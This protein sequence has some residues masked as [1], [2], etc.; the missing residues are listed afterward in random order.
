[1]KWNLVGKIRSPRDTPWANAKSRLQAKNDTCVFG[2][3]VPARAAAIDMSNRF[4]RKHDLN[5]LDGLTDER[6]IA[7]AV[8]ALDRMIVPYLLWSKERGLAEAGDKLRENLWS[9]AATGEPASDEQSVEQLYPGPGDVV[10]LESAYAESFLE[11]LQL[12][13]L[14]AETGDQMRLV[15][16]REAAYSMADAA[17]SDMLVRGGAGVQWTPEVESAVSFHPW[18]LRE[19]QVQDADVMAASGADMLDTLVDE[20]RATSKAKP[21]VSEE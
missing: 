8:A 1:M 16:I 9:Y 20:L 2:D 14:F 7:V 18:V 13:A 19:L 17:A 21:V 5:V 15:E 10:T 6:R 4:D 11:A 3:G 12:L